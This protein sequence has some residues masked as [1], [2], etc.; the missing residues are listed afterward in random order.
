MK[1]S[2]LVFLGLVLIQTGV[3]ADGKTRKDFPWQ[4]QI[5]SGSVGAGPHLGYNINQWVFV[6]AESLSRKETTTSTFGTSVTVNQS[7]N[8]I[9][10]R[11]ST[12]ENSGFYL[13]AGM[14]SRSWSA[15]SLG[16]GCIGTTWPYTCTNQESVKI[17]W[18]DTAGN[19][20]L[21]W[22]W[23]GD[24]GFSGGWGFSSISGGD[25]EITVTDLEGNATAAQV[26]EEEKYWNDNFAIYYKSV[27]NLHIN[28]GWNF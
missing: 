27:S 14:V 21:G 4:A 20:G 7:T 9:L 16:Y 22:N 24:G 5:A 25:P 19:V 3:Y 12:W 17:K 11:F 23:V 13:Q 6:G 28:F 26:A 15:E 10:A 2:V 18:P 1:K 8:Q